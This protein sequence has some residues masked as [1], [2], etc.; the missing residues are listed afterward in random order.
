MAVRAVM[1]LLMENQK[2]ALH[3]SE[4]PAV[5]PLSQG[6][7]IGDCGCDLTSSASSV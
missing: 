6:G 3:A 5:S 7:R 4:N 1:P 2:V